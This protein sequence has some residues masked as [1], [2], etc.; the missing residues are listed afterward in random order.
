MGNVLERFKDKLKQAEKWVSKYEDGSFEITESEEQKEKIIKNWINPKGLM[1]YHKKAIY[2]FWELQK[3]KKR[4]KR[5]ERLF[6]ELMDD[7]F[8]N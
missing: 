2:A 4:E 3:K 5:T 6:E 8:Q 1:G 7:N